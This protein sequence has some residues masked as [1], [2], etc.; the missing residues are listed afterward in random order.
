MDY[1]PPGSSVHR[2]FPGK[3]TGMGCNFLLQGNLTESEIEAG[4]P[5]EPPGKPHGNFYFILGI[6]LLFKRIGRTFGL[7]RYIFL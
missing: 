2:D 6:F 3:N 5:A 4:S 7:R 1:S